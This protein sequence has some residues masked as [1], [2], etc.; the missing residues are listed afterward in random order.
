VVGALVTRVRADQAAIGRALSI[1][2]HTVKQHVTNVFEKLGVQ[3]RVQAA[4]HA[5]RNGLV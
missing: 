1:S 3:S 5:V 2:K 4:V